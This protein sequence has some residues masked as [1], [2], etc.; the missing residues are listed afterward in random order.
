MMSST[1]DALENRDIVMLPGVAVSAAVVAWMFRV[2]EQGATFSVDD[3]NRHERVLRLANVSGLDQGDRQF[4][5]A[6]LQEMAQVLGRFRPESCSFESSGGS[7][8]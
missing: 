2:E 8:E 4:F 7:R 5:D 3:S 6:H 1:G